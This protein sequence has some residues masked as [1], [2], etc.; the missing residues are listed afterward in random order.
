MNK[1]YFNDIYYD[2]IDFYYWEPQDL[3]KIKNPKNK[4]NSP[5]KVMK[6]VLKMEVSLNHIFNIF[7][8]LAPKS[9]FNH[10]FKQAFG[11]YQNDIFIE[12]SDDAVMIL[13]EAVQPDFFFV[14][15][16]QVIAIEMKIKYDSDLEQLMKYLLLNVIYQEERKI[17]LPYKILFLG[18]GKFEN[19]WKDSYKNVDELKNAFKNYKFPRKTK[20]GN[21]TLKEYI[22]KINLL[23][24]RCEISYI[25]YN[26]F[27]RILKKE[28]KTGSEVYGKLLDGIVKELINRKLINPYGRIRQ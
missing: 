25:N 15:G 14:G 8:S 16:K 24:N 7:F 5:E 4:L 12:D 21:I 19:L 1:K 17:T 9:F 20:K 3:G 11:G 27:F 22:D 13:K 28:Q 23:L 18:P 6:H 26:D 2:I 10:F